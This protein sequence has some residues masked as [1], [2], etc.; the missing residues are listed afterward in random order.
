VSLGEIA[1]LT[2]GLRQRLEPRIQDF[3]MRF[4]DELR[5]QTVRDAAGDVLEVGFGTARNSSTTAR[6]SRR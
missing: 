3:M 4:M 2:K 5:P 1:T 6:D